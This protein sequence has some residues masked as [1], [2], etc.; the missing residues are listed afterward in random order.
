M[1]SNGF[2]LSGRLVSIVLAVGV[3]A[4]AAAA[5]MLT[6]KTELPAPPEGV[7]IEMLAEITAE[8]A[9]EATPT[10]AAE[11][12]QIE[13]AQEAEPGDARDVTGKEVGEV[14][15]LDNEKTEVAPDEAK[16][17]E[18][19]TNTSEAETPSETKP[20]ETPDVAALAD[21]TETPEVSTA[22]PMEV[23]PVSSPVE[24]E[25]PVIEA[26][27]A[28]ALSNKPKPK[29]A[30][31]KTAK[32]KKEQR[33]ASVAGTTVSKQAKRTGASSAVVSGGRQSSSAYA[34]IV[35]SRLAGKRSR[36]QSMLGSAMR[37]R[38][39]LTFSI[40]AGGGVSSVSV[41]SS[42]G[43]SRF[44]SIAKS[45]VASTSF[46]PPPNGRFSGRIPFNIASQ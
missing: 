43:N 27:H 6:P 10:V 45:I 20:T 37:G 46:P 33:R 44:D 11:A 36:L 32:K 4:A 42:S 14:A 2:T 28:P 26:P 3:H 21:P 39:V 35:Q 34:S 12:T 17:V 9:D 30:A 13:Q 31:K 18:Q 5:F 24:M 38:V 16:P 29:P 41:T 1:T 25:K 7:E 19:E 40:G 22:E 23:P 15:A 8:V